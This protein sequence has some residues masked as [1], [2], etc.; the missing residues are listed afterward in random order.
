MRVKEIMTPGPACCAP[1]T[2]LEK[3]ASLMLENDCGEIPV[4][5]GTKLVGVVTDRDIAMR[6]FAHAKN[7]L[8]VPVKN[9]MTRDV[10]SVDEDT[11]LDVALE[12]MEE[13]RVRR[14]PVTRNGKVVG[15]VSQSDL[16]PYVPATKFIEFVEAVSRAGAQPYNLT[17]RVEDA[18][19]NDLHASAGEPQSL[20]R[21]GI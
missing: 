19:S 17:V 5:D 10:L 3:V 7:P 9:I 11:P 13:R 12:S 14:L 21:R 20:A 16:L 6:G 1:D 4:V 15:I 18:D 2:R 8:D